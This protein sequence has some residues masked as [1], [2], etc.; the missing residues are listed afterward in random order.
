MAD[1]SL[2]N[3]RSPPLSKTA[4]ESNFSP[5]GHSGCQIPYPRALHQVKFQ[6]V[7]LA[8]WGKLLI[9]ALVIS[10]PQP[11]LCHADIY[12]SW[13]FWEF[14]L[15]KNPEERIICFI[16]DGISFDILFFKVDRIILRPISDNR[17]YTTYKVM[18]LE[19]L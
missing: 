8:S 3:P 11:F 19:I 10:A 7:S 15:T 5:W 16:L 18:Y 14:L 1:H 17:S 6:C 13:G 9:G 4:A 2:L 12:W